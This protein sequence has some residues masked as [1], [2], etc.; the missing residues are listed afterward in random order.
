MRY[1]LLPREGTFYKANLHSH[2]TISDGRLTPEEMRDFYREHGYDVLAITDHEIMRD[3]T[4]LSLPGFLI[5]NGYEIYV[6]ERLDAPRIA[7]NCHINLIAKT[8]DV[9]RQIAVDPKYLKYLDKN[10]LTVDDVPRVGELR[11][12]HYCPRDINAIIREAT[13]NG[14]IVAYN[15]P[16]WSLETIE[17]FGK[18][19]GVYAMEVVNYSSSLGG[20]PENDGWAYDQMLRLGKNIWC[21]ANDDNH[22]KYPFG[23]PRCDSFG[24]FN[25]IKA[26]ELSYEAIIDALIKGEF[27]ASQGPEIYDLYIEDNQLHVAC[28]PAVNVMLRM[29]G[30]TGLR[31]SVYAPLGETITEAVFDLR[32]EDQYV[33][34]EVTDRSGRKAFTHAYTLKGMVTV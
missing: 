8:P 19:D 10:G 21:L 14:Y 18:Y 20:F 13:E 4:D 2:S 1:D 17:E 33:R 27:Y 9:I 28:S 34:V 7:K 26:K 31:G 16:S 25:M 12:R 11:D 30:R 24:G 32:A 6:R 22:N 23:D 29:V 3:H 5:L 15:H